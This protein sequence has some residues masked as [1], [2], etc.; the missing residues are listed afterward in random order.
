MKKRRFYVIRK[1]G[2]LFHRISIRFHRDRPLDEAFVKSLAFMLTEEM[3]L[4]KLLAS[5]EQAGHLQRCVSEPGILAVHH[6][7]GSIRRSADWTGEDFVYI[8]SATGMNACRFH[9]KVYCLVD[10]KS[11]L[12]RIFV[13]DYTCQEEGNSHESGK[14]E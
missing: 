2:D 8:Y 12:L 10:F 3:D 6:G 5:P 11:R 9:R 13:V 7:L 1:Q 14:R 4:S